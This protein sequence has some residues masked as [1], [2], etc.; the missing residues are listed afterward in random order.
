MN[1]TSMN[2]LDAGPGDLETRYRHLKEDQPDIRA[3]NVAAAL[4]VSEGE[5]LAARVGK[6]AMRLRDEPVEILRAL[7]P[8]GQLMALT[9]NE[10]CVH[11]R[12][13][14]YLGG[15]FFSH[16]KT[17]SGLFVNPDIDLRLFMD[18]WRHCFAVVEQSRQGP[19]KSLQF[20]DKSGTAVHKIYLTTGSREAAYDD[21]VTSFLAQ[22]QDDFI[23]TEPYAPAPPDLPDHAIDR[24]GFREAW[25]NLQDTHDFF[26]LLKK[27]TLGREQ[28]FRLIGADFA[29]RVDKLAVRQVLEA[30]R[31]AECPIMV[32]VGNRGCIQ[33]HSGPVHKLVEHGPWYNVLDPLFNLHL[34][35]DKVVSSWVTRKPTV[36]GIVTALELFDAGGEVIATLFGKR[37]PGV[38]ELEQWREIIATLEPLA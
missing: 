28:S 27:F 16:G 32:F 9:R 15:K 8:L 10:Y 17:L 14:E 1:Q 2:I 34:R 19:R 21:L 4:G 29:C 37:K 22:R 35:D 26:P 31:D 38:P 7:E 13:G 30:A 20:F 5:L 6:D 12:K 11:E 25:K 33:I 23:E 36:D 24:N 3:R 18:H